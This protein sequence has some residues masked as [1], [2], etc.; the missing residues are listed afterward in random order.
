MSVHQ[1]L[2]PFPSLSETGGHN[3]TEPTFDA[4]LLYKW[5]FVCRQVWG[6]GANTM[7][8]QIATATLSHN[9]PHKTITGSLNNKKRTLDIQW[10]PM[11]EKYEK[12]NTRNSRTY[13]CLG[14][15]LLQT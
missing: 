9:L 3:V 8:L 7:R 2:F 14:L 1:Q 4:V 11:P 6:G 5:T 13:A 15:C 12:P 10:D